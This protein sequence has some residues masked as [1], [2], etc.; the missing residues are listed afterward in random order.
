MCAWVHTSRRIFWR[1]KL[2]A[3]LFGVAP[4]LLGSNPAPWKDKI[5]KSYWIHHNLRLIELQHHQQPPSASPEEKE[6]RN[7][8]GQGVRGICGMYWLLNTAGFLT[9]GALLPPQFTVS[10]SL[11]SFSV[12]DR[13]LINASEED[14][15][16]S[17]STNRWRAA[18]VRLFGKWGPPKSPRH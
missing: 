10:S 2:A 14:A 9:K 6:G 1:H 12:C 13:I 17:C 5:W 18:N 7:S 8:E 4:R 11:L 15:E 16:H 3:W